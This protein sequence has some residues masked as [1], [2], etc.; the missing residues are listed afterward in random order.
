MM[1][2]RVYVF[3][4]IAALMTAVATLKCFTADAFIQCVPQHLSRVNHSMIF[5]VPSNSHR[6]RLAIRLNATSSVTRRNEKNNDNEDDKK[7]GKG[8]FGIN[9]NPR[10]K[11]TEK[12]KDD[13]E[14][15]SD[16]KWFAKFGR[17]LKN[18]DGIRDKRKIDRRKTRSSTKKKSLDSQKKVESSPAQF[19]NA[20]GGSFRDDIASSKAEREQANRKAEQ[21]KQIN[22][23][24]KRKKAGKERKATDKTNLRKYTPNV[25]P[26]DISK[27][28]DVSGN[29]EKTKNS[30]LDGIAKRM[31]AIGNNKG[32]KDDSKEDSKDSSSN[33]LNVVSNAIASVFNQNE[34]EWV[35]VAPKRIIA[36][37]EALPLVAAGLDLLLVASRDGKKLYCVANQCSHFGTPLETGLIQKLEEDTAGK[38]VPSP[39]GC[40]CVV[41]PLHRTAFDLETGEVV[42]P[43]CPHPPGI[44]GVVGAVKQKNKLPTFETRIKGKNIE[45]RISSVLEASNE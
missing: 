42:G 11:D 30:P 18:D 27:N 34:E 39:Q 1:R 21:Q 36:P 2:D 7:K 6:K 40:D 28:I 10:G 37:G 20:F 24:K 12:S 13:N 16:E 31:Q 4:S 26:G 33:P 43:W 14:D 15:Q 5:S 32:N 45:V 35:V 38:V 25:K 8:I 29:N 3:M 17:R 23:E 9:I 19:I 44:G 22:A 41:C